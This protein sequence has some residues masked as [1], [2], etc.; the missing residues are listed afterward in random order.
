MVVFSGNFDRDVSYMKMAIALAR[1]GLGL[2]SPNPAVGTVVV[3]GD[4]VVGQGYHT[5]AGKPH[6]EV[7]ALKEAG[8][9]AKGA[10]LFI[11]LEPCCHTGRTPPCVPLILKS[12]IK[13][14]VIGMIDPNPLVSGKGIRE[15]KKTGAEVIVGVLEDKCKELNEAWI[16][17]ITKKIPF[18]ILKAA[19]SLDGKI[20]THTGMSRWI[21][22]L[23]SRRLV[24]ELR[25]LADA[26]VVGK[27]T[28]LSDNP[29][30]TARLP[31]RKSYDLYRFRQPRPVILDYRLE[32]PINARVLSH[33]A[34]AI[35]AA[36]K[37]AR[38]DQR[39]RLEAK[40][41]E[42]LILPGRNGM[43][44]WLPL[45]KELGKREI[46]SLIIEGGASVFASAIEERVVDKVYFFIAP[47]IIGGTKALGTVGGKG[48]KK[49]L[50][51]PRLKNTRVRRIGEDLLVEGYL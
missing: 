33:P 13:R 4:E 38:R 35:I 27:N 26:L 14:V 31:G 20:A 9:K 50:D 6:A 37:G 5:A 19:Q 16:K 10:E 29:R 45:L 46:T 43:I 11:N 34:G 42:I 17:Y 15:L 44:S 8:R 49:I 32:V 18:V 30:L 51:A 48:I 2:T 23:E 39:R 36:G 24:H 41:V 22:S 7:V 25:S 28:V 40:G 12:G 1:R 21:T 47:I 3:R